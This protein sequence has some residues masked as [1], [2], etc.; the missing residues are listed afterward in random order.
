MHAAVRVLPEPAS[1]T[2]PQ[3]AIV[4]PSAVKLRLPVGA[5]PVTEPLNVTPVPTVAGLSELLTK[6]VVAAAEPGVTYTH[7][8]LLVDAVFAASPP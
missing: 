1:A 8:E 5:L 3:P 2:A 4:A 6:V 7:T